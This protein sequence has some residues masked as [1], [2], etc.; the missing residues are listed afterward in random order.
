MNGPFLDTEGLTLLWGK[1]KSLVESS[2][3]SGI[4]LSDYATKEELAAK[5]DT[6]SV[7]TKTSDLT[8]DSDFITIADVEAK[9]YVTTDNFRTVVQE[10]KEQ[11]EGKQDTLT[12][13][14]NI[15][16]IN[17]K[18]LLGEGDITITE[19]GSIDLSDYYTQEQVDTLLGDK[20]NT[21]AVPTKLSQLT[22]DANYTTMSAVEAKGYI[23]ST[24]LDAKG[25][26]TDVSDLATKAE[27]LKTAELNS[28]VETSLTSNTIKM[29]TSK[30]ADNT[31]LSESSVKLNGASTTEAG[32]LTAADKTSLETLKTQ[33]AY[34]D[35][36]NDELLNSIWFNLDGDS[37]AGNALFIN[38]S[39]SSSWSGAKGLYFDPSSFNVSYDSARTYSHTPDGEHYVDTIVIN[40]KDKY[41]GVFTIE[42]GA[43]IITTDSLS[44]KNNNSEMLFGYEVDE[45]IIEFS[46]NVSFTGTSTFTGDATFNGAINANSDINAVGG[47][48]TITDGSIVAKETTEAGSVVT[49]SMS[50]GKIKQTT[51]SNLISGVSQISKFTIPDLLEVI[52]NLQKQ[53]TELETKV[54]G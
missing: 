54:T 43:L 42:D 19:G 53:I 18:S 5:A 44:F 23:T 41:S 27:A 29:S 25:Y 50:N 7:P 35:S 15:K 40:A 21:T 30:V 11:L 4:D 17:G 9:Y 34:A 2:G 51:V 28:T 48:L 31:I 36:M 16:T 1:V 37:S 22:N 6:T 14:T 38:S 13:G 3:G 45:N 39:G 12:S 49:Y 46:K 26:I 52:Y 10:V 24:D 8:N 33:W 20:A 32:L 47:N